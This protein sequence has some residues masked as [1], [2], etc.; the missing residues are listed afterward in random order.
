MG[1]PDPERFV[2][3]FTRF[4]SNPQPGEFADLWADRGTLLHPTMDKSID[5]SEIPDYVAR[6][7]SLAPD[8]T[9]APK[10]WASSG[11]ELFI[12]WTITVT[13]PD[14]GEQ[15][16]W[17]GVDRFTLDGDR[18][19]EGIAYFDTAPIWARMDPTLKREGDIVEAAAS[20]RE[21]VA[22][23]AKT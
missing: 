1:A 6:I 18:A 9:L 3:K 22:E 5:K 17:D 21:Q 2:E 13:P 20:E 15:M 12:E 7:K 14:A 10:R 16:S 23:P 8:I 19:I 11:N 4:W